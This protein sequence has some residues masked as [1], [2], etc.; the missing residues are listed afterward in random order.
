MKKYL[1]LVLILLVG[2]GTAVWR[3]QDVKHQVSDKSNAAA[4]EAVKLKTPYV[5]IN[6]VN[7]NVELAQTETGVQKGL[8]GR[9]SLAADKGMLF[10]FNK[11]DYYRFWMPNMNFPIDIIW[12]SQNT[13]VGIHKNVSN[14]FDPANPKFYTPPRP[15]DRVLEVNAGFAQKN[16]LKVG[17]P[18]NFV[19]GRPE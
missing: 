13:I 19:Q 7:I 18:F 9:E 10:I 4:V 2:L 6:G 16:N 11:P 17:N 8:S 3:A 14:Q 15:V 1:L 5:E 12:I